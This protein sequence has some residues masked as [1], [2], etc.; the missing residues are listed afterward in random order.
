MSERV[1]PRCAGHY[2]A[3]GLAAEMMINALRAGKTIWSLGNGG[4]AEQASH[5][6]AE[7]V[8]RFKAKGRRPLAAVSLAANTATITAIANDFGYEQV[9][10]RQVRAL[11]QPGDVVLA[12]STSGKSENVLLAV[13]AANDLGAIT[14]GMVAYDFDASAPN[15]HGLA[16]LTLVANGIGA[17]AA[18]EDHLRYI[19]AL[20]G[21]IDAAFAPSQTS[22]GD[23]HGHTSQKDQA[24]QEGG[25]ATEEAGTTRA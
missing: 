24:A 15:L 20:C 23:H 9:F 17:A 12:L 13:A 5:F 25:A 10:S 8:G 6:A 3:L 16:D 11:V 19:H 21:H 18:Q 7:L 2:P 22:E 4:S 1:V 14:I